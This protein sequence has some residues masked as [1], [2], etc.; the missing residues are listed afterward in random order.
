MAK[1]ASVALLPA[2]RF[3][4]ACAISLGVWEGLAVGTG[5][6]PTV[7]ATCRRARS[8]KLGALA[9]AAWWIGLGWHLL[10]SKPSPEE[11]TRR[12]ATPPNRR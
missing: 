1:G 2:R 8:R 9:I 7:T 6:V 3:W 10:G 11:P 4:A 5:R 12:P